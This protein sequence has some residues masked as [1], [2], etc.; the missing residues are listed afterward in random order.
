MR[1]AIR[2]SLAIFFIFLFGNNHVVIANNNLERT[3]TCK[4]IDYGLNHPVITKT[5]NL[6]T[7]HDSRL[8]RVQ[9][10]EDACRPTMTPTG[11]KQCYLRTT[12]CVVVI[13]RCIHCCYGPNGEFLGEEAE[14]C[15][16]CAIFPF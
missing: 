3:K 8:F 4:S 10:G 13:L 16:G 9:T 1:I 15:G 2:G 7:P 5:P 11:Q 14:N 6:L 12:K